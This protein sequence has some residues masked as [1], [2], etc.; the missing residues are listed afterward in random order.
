MLLNVLHTISGCV[1]VLS[2]LGKVATHYLLNRSR[3]TGAGFNSI[4]VMPLQYLLPYKYDVNIKYQSLKYWCNF[5]LLLAVIAL[6]LNIIFGVL[7][8]L[9]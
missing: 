3:G 7:I 5:L 9:N 1:I 2:L 6:V 8:Y 4:I